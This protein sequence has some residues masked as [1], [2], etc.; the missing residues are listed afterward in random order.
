[1][2]L[3]RHHDHIATLIPRLGHALAELVNQAENIAA[4]FVLEQALQAF[5]TRGFVALVSGD[6]TAD[7]GFVNLVVQFL[8][9]GQQHKGIGRGD[10]AMH[11]LAEEHHGVA[12][13]AALGMPEHA[14]LARQHICIAGL[15]LGDGLVDAQVLVVACHHF[16]SV[17]FAAVKE[18]EVLYQVQQCTLGAHTAQQDRQNGL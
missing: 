17:F 13:A 10:L 7:E 15:Q 8:A 14:Q 6:T 12:L 18:R 9:V 16:Q 3:I 5:G 2:C 11:L 4:V 1:M